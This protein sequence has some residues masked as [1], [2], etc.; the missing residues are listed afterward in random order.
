MKVCRVVGTHARIF[1]PLPRIIVITIIII[2][3]VQCCYRSKRLL[4]QVLI[5]T[6]RVEQTSPTQFGDVRSRALTSW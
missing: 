5:N 3:L 4:S 1:V 2:I 6:P